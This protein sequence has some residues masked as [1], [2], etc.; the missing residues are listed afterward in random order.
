MIS[1]EEITKRLVS[2]YERKGISNFRN[3]YQHA[4]PF[5]G[6]GFPD[7]SRYAAKRV[8][9]TCVGGRSDFALANKVAGFKKTPNGFTW[10]H[11]QDMITM[12]L[13]PSDLHEVIRHTGGMAKLGQ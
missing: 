6:Q 7:F 2:Y 11:N 1:V 13:V 3:P 5:T 10:H 12:E 4:I 8:R 9:I